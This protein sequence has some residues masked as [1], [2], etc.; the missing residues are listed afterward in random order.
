MKLPAARFAAG[1]AFRIPRPL[2]LSWLAVMMLPGYGLPVVGSLM[3]YCLPRKLAGLLAV[4][5]S[6]KLPCRISAEGTVHW[7]LSVKRYFTHSVP[8]YQKNLVLSLL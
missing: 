1:Y 2:G 3:M 5:S 7:A 6:L 4:R 8:Q